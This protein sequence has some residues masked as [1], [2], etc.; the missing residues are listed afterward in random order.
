VREEVRLASGDYVDMKALEP[1]MRH[2]LDTYI[3]AEDSEKVSAFDDMSLVELIVAQ[4]EDAIDALPEGIRKSEVAMAETIENNVRKLII[5][6]MA[7]NPKYYE[8]MS[9]LLDA[10]IKQRKEEAIKYKEYL[11]QIVELTRKVRVPTATT[12]PLNINSPARQAL[13]DNLTEAE[14]EAIADGAAAS[15]GD[16]KPRERAVRLL[17]DSIQAVKKADWRGNKFKEREVRGAIAA[18]LGNVA[19]RIDALFE[20]VKNQREY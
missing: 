14:C 16:A 15:I 18:L 5:D 17:H 20:L 11:R 19:D 7:V 10:L 3:R 12:Y 6:E 8:K 13:F 4:G 9:E 1:A 2:L